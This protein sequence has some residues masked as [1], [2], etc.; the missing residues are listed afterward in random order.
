MTDW[1]SSPV[2][3][4]VLI[5]AIIIS[6]WFIYRSFKTPPPTYPEIVICTNKD[7]G[8]IFE[9][10]AKKGKTQPF[11]CP[12]CGEKK[13]YLAMKCYDCGEIFPAMIAN[14]KEGHQCPNPY[15][16]SKSVHPLR[17]IPKEDYKSSPE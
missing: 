8:Y 9:V 4:I 12:E 3:G 17:E 6:G 16:G 5:L 1:K 11:L 10:T 14:P 2:V 7:C 15:C 13:A